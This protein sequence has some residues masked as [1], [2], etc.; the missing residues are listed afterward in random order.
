MGLSRDP[1]PPRT[2]PR[3]RP[4]ARVISSR[5]ALASPCRLTP[6]T[7]P[8]SVH[9]MA[10]HQNR[11]CRHFYV[12]P[13]LTRRVAGTPGLAAAGLAE[14]AGRL[15]L[16]ILCCNSAYGA[17][18]PAQQGAMRKGSNMR[19]AGHW[20]PSAKPLLSIMTLGLILFAS[21][22]MATQ[23]HAENWFKLADK[24]CMDLDSFRI[25]QDWEHE[26]LVV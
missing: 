9:C 5:M 12:I 25:V 17:T 15:A 11:H 14:T 24:S 26:S 13:G 20:R 2:R 8:S 16:Q 6:S 1:K 18:V 10:R 19:C 4:C 21:L 7:M 23:A 3:W 22:T